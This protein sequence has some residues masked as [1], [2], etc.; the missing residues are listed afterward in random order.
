MQDAGID[1]FCIVV[2]AFKTKQLAEPYVMKSSSEMV[3]AEAEDQR[4]N[5]LGLC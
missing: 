4:Y 2:D 3:T 5:V 1:G